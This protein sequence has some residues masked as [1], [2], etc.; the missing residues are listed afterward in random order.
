MSQARLTIRFRR[1]WSIVRPTNFQRLD[2]GRFAIRRPPTAIRNA[3]DQRVRRAPNDR[4]RVFHPLS[5]RLLLDASSRGFRAP[6]V[7]FTAR[8][9]RNGDD[10]IFGM[11]LSR[12]A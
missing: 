2:V 12:H 8:L 7:L 9:A 5:N 4:H 11:T 6:F 3:F 1:A 10:D